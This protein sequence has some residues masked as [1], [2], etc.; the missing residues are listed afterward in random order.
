[1]ANYDKYE[2]KAG[3]F[4]APLAADWLKADVNTVFGVGLNA[5]GAVVKGSG[6]SGMIGVMI[7]TR[8]EKAGQVVDVMTSGEIVAFGGV[9]GTAYYA[10]ATTGIVNATKAVGKFRVGHTV[11]QDRLVVRFNPFAVAA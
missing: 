11:F 5:S 1:M 6:A 3:G 10:D 9:A 8:A 7:L 2:P 4:R